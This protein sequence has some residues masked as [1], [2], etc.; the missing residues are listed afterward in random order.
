[1]SLWGWVKRTYRKA[2]RTV[3]RVGR[4]A[5]Q[6]VKRIGRKAINYGR[7]AWSWTKKTAKQVYNRLKDYVNNPKLIVQDLVKG[8]IVLIK[9]KGAYYLKKGKEFVKATKELFQSKDWKQAME[10]GAKVAFLARGTLKDLA[11]ETNPVGQARVSAKQIYQADLS[12]YE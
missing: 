12:K 6:G 2:K 5:Y 4:K 9:I 11:S 1:M 3:R 7:K 8:T 10:R